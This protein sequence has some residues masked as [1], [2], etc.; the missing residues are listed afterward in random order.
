MPAL[1][2]RDPTVAAALV[3]GAFIA[4]T[5]APSSALAALTL[6]ET[7]RF[8][9]AHDPALVAKRANVANLESTYVKQRAAEFPS[10]SGQLANQLSKSANAQGQFAQFGVVP[11]TNFSQNTA[12][13]STQ[14][15]V[16]NGSL[17]Q[18]LAQEDRRQVEA[19][20][21]DLRRAEDETASD[22][23]AQFYGLV[24]KRETVLLDA[25]NRVYQQE[26][27]DAARANER[28]GRSAGVD[29]LRAQVAETRAEATLL[30]AQADEANARETLANRIGAPLEVAFAIPVRLPE[31][32]LPATPV[33]QLVAVAEAARPDI[34]SAAESVRAAVLASAAIDT[35][36]RP[37]IA[38]NGAFGNQNSPTLTANE[39]AQ[40]NAENAAAVAQYQLL[41]EIAPPSIVIPPPLVL[42]NVARGTPG[43]W[44]IGATASWSV[45][46]I[47]WG[48]RRAAHRAARAQIASSEAAL[49]GARSAVELDV[50]QS[51]RGAQTSAAN[52]QLA[53]LSARLAQESARIAQLQFKNGLISFT[54]ANATQQ[55]NL[56]AQ[57]DLAS[58][59]VSYVVSLVKLRIA[60][61]TL[62]PVTA[63]VLP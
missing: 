34:A 44:Q 25:S 24:G 32:P 53:K 50:R 63:A 36:L 22:V 13:V 43:F 7:I 11:L 38:L 60:L 57:T 33:D 31:P 15:T 8:A 37:Q 16:Y 45:P 47:D 9:L 58:A 30:S 54:D 35:D 20:Q 21:S 17:N 14:W 49:Q 6:P 28:V 19:A 62:D 39:Q 3:C 41:R 48:T 61:G 18:V 10:I 5:S 29:T 4:A 52:L 42:P 12:Q 51:L 56:S 46:F 2:F 55:T 23:A 27:L 26:L 40:V 59:A 1:F